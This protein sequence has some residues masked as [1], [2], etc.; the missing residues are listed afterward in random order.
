[1][2]SKEVPDAP[3]A[4]CESLPGSHPDYSADDKAVI[5]HVEKDSGGAGHGCPP[6]LDGGGTRLNISSQ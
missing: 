1:M 4:T 3:S 5:D 6:L 2:L